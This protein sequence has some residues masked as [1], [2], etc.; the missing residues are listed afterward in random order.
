[1]RSAAT[2][3]GQVEAGLL[4]GNDTIELIEIITE[5]NL[6]DEFNGRYDGHANSRA[7]RIPE[8]TKRLKYLIQI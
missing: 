2:T 5:R 6:P 3:R 1:M 8:N 7:L 4:N